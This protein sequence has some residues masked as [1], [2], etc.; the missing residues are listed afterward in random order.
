MFDMEDDDTFF[1]EQIFRKRQDGKQEI[2]RI[3]DGQQP[4]QPRIRGNPARHWDIESIW[5]ENTAGIRFVSSM[6]CIISC[7]LFFLGQMHNLRKP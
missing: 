6:H 4:F 7:F 2:N 1:G 5:Q 3:L